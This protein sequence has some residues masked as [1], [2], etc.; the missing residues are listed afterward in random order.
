M[1][2]GKSATLYTLRNTFVQHVQCIEYGCIRVYKM[3]SFLGNLYTN[4]NHFDRISIG[5]I[6][7]A[8]YSIAASI[9]TLILLLW[10]DQ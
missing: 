9:A 7:N 2:M 1:G 3:D 5:F 8:V 6:Q 10:S 4:R